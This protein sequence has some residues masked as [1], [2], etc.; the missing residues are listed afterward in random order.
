MNEQRNLLKWFE[1][2]HLKEDLRPLVEAYRQL[3]ETVVASS[4]PSA[5]QTLA[6]RFLEQ[7]KDYAVRSLILTQRNN[8][9]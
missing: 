8:K 2:E 4:L 3:G 6:I 9:E 1:T 7:S 5:E